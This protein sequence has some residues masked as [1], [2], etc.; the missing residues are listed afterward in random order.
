MTPDTKQRTIAIIDKAAFFFFAALV[1]FLPI[2]KASIESI[3]GFLFL[4]FLLKISIRRP[5]LDRVKAFFKDRI[6][7]SLL[8]FYIAIALSMFASGEFI[9]SS[10]KAWFFKWGEWVIL[11]YLIRVLLTREKVKILFYVFFAGAFLITINGIFQWLNWR[12][13][14]LGNNLIQSY[15]FYAVC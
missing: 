14:V 5:S 2:A 3:F 15:D 8:I 10:F 6:N 7:L 1:F 4:C 13:F 12:G 11:F 9:R